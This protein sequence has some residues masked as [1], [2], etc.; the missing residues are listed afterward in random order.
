MVGS[1]LSGRLFELRIPDLD[2]CFDDTGDGWALIDV[3]W[4]A[5]EC[6][7]SAVSCDPMQAERL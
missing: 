1:P 2:V 4:C 3:I 5:I 7:K 6:L